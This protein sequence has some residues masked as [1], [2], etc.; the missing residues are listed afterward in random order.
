[1]VPGGWS[2]AVAAVK[3]GVA[4]PRRGGN[5][6]AFQIAHVFKAPGGPRVCSGHTKRGRVWDERA[7]F[8]P[9][10][11]PGRDPGVLCPARRMGRQI[12]FNHTMQARS[13][14]SVL[15][16]GAAHAIQRGMRTTSRLGDAGAAQERALAAGLAFSRKLGQD[17]AQR[18]PPQAV[19][20]AALPQAHAELA[21]QFQAQLHRQMAA[22]E[23]SAA[24]DA[25]PTATMQAA[26]DH[27]KG[28]PLRSKREYKALMAEWVAR[29]Q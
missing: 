11:K 12:A 20:E 27:L 4:W 14:L 3:A 17:A 9:W 1:M 2:A 6:D 21:L 26:A 15:S 24:A 19:Y 13:Q 18:P 28:I 10:S 29:R 8:D 23:A 16:R 5:L 25:S 22:V 7:R